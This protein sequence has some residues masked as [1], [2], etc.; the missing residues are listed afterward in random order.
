M[1]TSDSTMKM[2]NL[3]NTSKSLAIKEYDQRMIH[4]FIINEPENFDEAFQACSH[5]IDQYSNDNE[6][7][8]RLDED[9]KE[10]IKIYYKNGVSSIDDINEY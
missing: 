3:L 10:P 7:V 9:S 4:I 8:E 5:F 1:K 2:L 6:K